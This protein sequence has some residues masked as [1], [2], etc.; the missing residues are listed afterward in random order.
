MLT[1]KTIPEWEITEQKWFPF[2]NEGIRDLVHA[3]CYERLLLNYVNL[4]YNTSSRNKV[5]EKS[6]RVAYIRKWLHLRFPL[7]PL[8]VLKPD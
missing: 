7:F 1:T 8:D 5:M 2:E 6:V 4:N 3:F